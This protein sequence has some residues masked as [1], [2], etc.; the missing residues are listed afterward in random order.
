MRAKLASRAAGAAAGFLARSADHLRGF[1]KPQKTASP[2]I[3]FREIPKI[4]AHPAPQV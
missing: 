2:F 3:L 4:S 1:A